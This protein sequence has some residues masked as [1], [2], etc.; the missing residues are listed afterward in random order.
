MDELWA[1]RAA[2][3]NARFADQGLPVRVASHTTIWALLYTL[4][5]RYNWMLQYYLRAEGV[6]L[7]WVGSGR[8]I[9][10]LNYGE[11]DYRAV[12]DRIVAAAKAMAADGWWWQAPGVTD[13]AIRRSVLKEMIAKRLGK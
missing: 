12:A 3:L 5:S 11:A 13:K 8:I 4:P 1:D 10:S 7:S 2:T 6:A 9:F